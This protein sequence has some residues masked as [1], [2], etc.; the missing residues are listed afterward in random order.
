MSE[1]PNYMTF[2]HTNVAVGAVSTQLVAANTT[3]V[4]YILIQNLSA[5]DQ[6]YIKMGA[7]A[8][9]GQGIQLPEA[10]AGGNAQGAYELSPGAGN[11]T[12]EQING[13][14][15]G[16]GRIVAVTIGV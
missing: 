4:R 8:V 9:V 3:G 7:A 11:I 16:A 6:V 5:L 13:I 14:S 2:T 15:G 10:D 1:Y 12:L